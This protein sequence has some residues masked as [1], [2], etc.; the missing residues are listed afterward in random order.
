[1]RR[2]L[3][4]ALALLAACGPAPDPAS[5]P[6]AV[7]P[8]GLEP[9]PIYSLLGFRQDLGLTS[10]QVTA[11][12][13]IAVAVRQQNAPLVQEL[14]DRNPPRAQQR[15]VILV[16]TATQPAL[17]QLRANNRAAVAAVGEVLT[18]EQ[19]TS[20]C[21]LFEQNGRD[22]TRRAEQARREQQQQ[23][24]RRTGMVADTLG[25][26]GRAGWTWCAPRPAPEE[27]GTDGQNPE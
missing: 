9:P 21:R 10:Q 19:R 7:T 20:A 11:L 18:P 25:M 13:S 12:D 17:E 22:R 15:G 3:L 1:M 26:P 4:A 8:L 23:Q 5:A 14:R 24:Q 2:S 6:R 16:D 27:P